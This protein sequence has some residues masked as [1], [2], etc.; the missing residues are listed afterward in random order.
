MKRE[1]SNAPVI[2]LLSLG[3]GVQSSTLYLMAVTG[4]I[5]PAPEFAIFA[6][7]Q[8]EPRAVY[9]HLAYLDEVGG[10][11]IPIRRVTAGS[12]RNDIIDG[13][14]R[15]SRIANA[16]FWVE[17]RDGRASKL[18]RTCTKEY[19]L[20]PI[21]REQGRLLHEFLGRRAYPA[22]S[23]EVWIGISTNESFRIKPSRNRYS[24]NRWP[25]IEDLKMNRADCINWLI[26]NGFRVPPKSSC[27]GCPYHDDAYWRW[28]LLTSPEEFV[29][30]CEF[31]HDIR[32]GLRGVNGVRGMRKGGEAF[33]HRSLVPLETIDF[34]KRD[35]QS[36]L[37]LL[38]QHVRGHAAGPV[39]LSEGETAL[40]LQLRLK[41]K[42][43]AEQE[44]QAY[45]ASFWSDPF[46]EECAGICGI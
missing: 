16:P 42:Q 41:A 11:K 8:W 43:Q 18:R 27:I 28:L 37:D 45:Q 34:L 31:D 2:R 6:D 39:I 24:Y 32:V 7:T 30:A 36:V 1:E 26:E 25:L 44:H 38:P 13:A 5:Q 3:A 17:G 4:F 9:D 20:E 35:E 19:K 23:V 10:L 29:Q 22:N 40:H 46:T 14:N 21:A 33:L 15:G 12:L